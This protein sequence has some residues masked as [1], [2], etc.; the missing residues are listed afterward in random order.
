MTQRTLLLNQWYF[1]HAILSWQDAVTL[2]YL[3]KADIVSSYDEEIRS[4]STSMPCPAVIRLKKKVASTKRGVKF[5]RINVYL[6]DDFTCC[7]CSTKLGASRLTYDHVVP[8]AQGGRTVWENIVTSCY[9]CNA[10][11]G[12]RTPAQAGLR[13]AHAPYHPASLPLAPPRIDA[14]DLPV[15]WKDFCATLPSHAI[16]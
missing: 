9:P 4:P 11:K 1:P 3:D 6:R 5:S 7:Y 10:K 13:L 12:N 15:E 16:A 2:V 14:S 8:R